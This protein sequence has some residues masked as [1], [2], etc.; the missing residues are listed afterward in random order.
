[1][2]Q[3][4]IDQVC[5]RL[6]QGRLALRGGFV[7]MTTMARSVGTDEVVITEL[8]GQFFDGNEQLKDQVKV[9]ALLA[10]VGSGR[11]ERPAALAEV[12]LAGM[13]NAYQALSG[14]ARL[15]GA[16][17]ADLTSLHTG[18]YAANEQVKTQLEELA[19]AA[20]PGGVT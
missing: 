15:N 9:L 12:S 5:E 18:F 17:G 8:H 4:Q 20:R 11:I 13:V 14:L 16:A 1:M 2:D 6:E 7:T 3:E 10:R 19:W